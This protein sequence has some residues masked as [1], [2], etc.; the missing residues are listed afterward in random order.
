VEAV[1]IE[2]MR[3]EVTRIIVAKRNDI[4]SFSPIVPVDNGVPHHELNAEP[5]ILRYEITLLGAHDKIQG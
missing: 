1:L 4:A 2:D 5:R 3:F